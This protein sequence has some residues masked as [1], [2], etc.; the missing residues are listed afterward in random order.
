MIFLLKTFQQPT[1]HL[2]NV[3]HTAYMHTHSLLFYCFL[4][5]FYFYP[6]I[7]CL[8]FFDLVMA[9]FLFFLRYMAVSFTHVFVKLYPLSELSVCPNFRVL[10]TQLILT[11][12]LK[13][14]PDIFFS[15]IAQSPT[16]ILSPHLTLYRT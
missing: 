11:H 12:F 14:S 5:L 10:F 3:F 16:V 7:P 9:H 4:K 1:Y 15:E 8:R 6:Y 2:P 13:L